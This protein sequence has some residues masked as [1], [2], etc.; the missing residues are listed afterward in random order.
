MLLGFFTH[1]VLSSKFGAMIF[2]PVRGVSLWARRRDFIDLPKEAVESPTKYQFAPV[3]YQV[4]RRNH[5]NFASK[6]SFLYGFYPKLLLAGILGQA[7]NGSLFV[8]P[9]SEAKRQINK[10]HPTCRIQ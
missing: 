9:V 2:D 3:A 7:S 1:N 10:K 6:V 5:S 4:T 8:T